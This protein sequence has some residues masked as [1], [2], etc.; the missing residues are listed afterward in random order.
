MRR[1]EAVT[2][3]TIFSDTPV[4]DSGAK[5]AQLFVGRTSLVA[6]IYGIKTDKEFVNTLEDN[7]RDCACAE[8]ST[9]IKDILRA[10]I[11]SDWQ[12]EPYQQKQNIPKNQC[13]IIKTATNHAINL[14][15]AP[16]DCW[17][18]AMSSII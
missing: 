14:C 15:R 5:A 10:L 3:D 11:I 2:T 13:A 12:S 9:R 1:T 7:I 16:A 4:V 17:L 8:T 6:D 18:L